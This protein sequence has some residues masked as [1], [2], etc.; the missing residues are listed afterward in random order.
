VARRY[1][2]SPEARQD[3]IEIRDYYLDE[4]GAAVARSVLTEITK[5]LGFLAGTPGAGHLR[6]DLTDAPVKFWAV[7]PYLIVY[8]PAMQPIGI[9]RVLHA[10]RDLMAMF[11]QRPPR[12]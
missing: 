4:A 2:L 12:A 8:D 10:S 11:Q 5:A 9:A 1:S 6:S 7:P 3:L